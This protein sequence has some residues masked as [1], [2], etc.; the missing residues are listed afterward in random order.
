MVDDVASERML[1]IDNLPKSK[2][3]YLAL[4]CVIGVNSLVSIGGEHWKRIRKMF[5]PAFAQNNLETMIPAIV[6]ESEVFIDKL[7]QIADS[8][9][10]VQMNQMTT[11]LSQRNP[12]DLSS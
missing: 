3:A 7:K 5:N 8:G 10:T 11:V 4:K 1:Q 6:E 2:P 9:K 12:S